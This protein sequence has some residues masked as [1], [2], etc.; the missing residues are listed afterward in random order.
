ML[1]PFFCS[2][3]VE[4]SLFLPPAR[5]DHVFLTMIELIVNISVVSRTLSLHGFARP[6]RGTLYKQGEMMQA[7]N[8]ARFQNRPSKN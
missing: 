1:S 6:T 8:W 7:R 4:D 2:I 5:N 3:R